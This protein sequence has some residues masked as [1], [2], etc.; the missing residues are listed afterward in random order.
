[1]GRE[2][3]GFASG[4]AIAFGI[5]LSLN[6]PVKPARNTAAQKARAR[7]PNGPGP[8]EWMK[9]LFTTDKNC[10]RHSESTEPA[11]LEPVNGKEPI[12]GNLGVGIYT[13]WSGRCGAG[14]GGSRGSD[15]DLRLEA[16]I[17]DFADVVSARTD[18]A[19]EGTTRPATM[20][21]LPVQS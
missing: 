20:G 16:T 21:G 11:R 10:R 6:V 12:E 5:S 4:L 9:N 13:T 19:D 3:V 18:S 7:Q 1:M 15:G 2:Q 17:G 8:V 14:R